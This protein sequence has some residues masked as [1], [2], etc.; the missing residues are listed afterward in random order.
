MTRMGAAWTRPLLHLGL[1]A[2]AV[3]LPGAGIIHMTGKL[4]GFEATSLTVLLESKNSL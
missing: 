3:A 4:H 2:G 1:H